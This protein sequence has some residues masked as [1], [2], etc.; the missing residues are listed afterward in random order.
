MQK[1]IENYLSH[2]NYGPEDVIICEIPGCG[3]RGVDVHH[4]IPRSKFGKK[5]K[6]EQDSVNNLI[7][8]CRSHHDDAHNNVLTKEY[9]QDLI[10]KR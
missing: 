7:G 4:I 10:S 9:L 8:L 5:R 6:D 1:H 3:Q 2:F